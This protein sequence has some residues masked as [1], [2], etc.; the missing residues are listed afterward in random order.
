MA[1]DLD[2]LRHV[3]AESARFQ[4]LLKV[5]DPAAPVPTCPGWDA[6]DLVWH[7]TEVQAFWGRVVQQRPAHPGELQGEDLVRPGDHAALLD[8]AERSSKELV[9]TLRRTPPDTPVWTW[10]DDHSAGFVLRRQAHEALVHRVD[11]ECTVGQ[12]TPLDPNLAADGVDEALRVML[13]GTPEGTRLSVDTPATVRLRCTDTGDSWLV[14]LA[15][16]D[17]TDEQ[18]APHSGPTLV[19]A[20]ED[21]DLPAAAT[22]SAA[23]GDLD[24]WL[25]GR[26]PLGEVNLAGDVRVLGGLREIVGSGIN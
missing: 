23:A 2:H 10:A 26:P 12:R 14:T 4:A 8:L 19:V 6:A 20:A 21:N 13:G 17:G 5:V 15:R 11:A 1:A 16:F 22:I 9:A 24:C 3:T 18:G 25:W 7:L